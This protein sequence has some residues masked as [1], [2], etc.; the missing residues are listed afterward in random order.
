[1]IFRSSRIQEPASHE[2]NQVRK[3]VGGYI[4]R[5][6]QQWIEPIEHRFDRSETLIQVDRNPSRFSI[7]ATRVDRCV[8]VKSDCIF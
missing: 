2:F 8:E 4:G 6:Q 3:L 7:V 1:M 5:I